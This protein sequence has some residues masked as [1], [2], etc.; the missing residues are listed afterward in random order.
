MNENHA[1][2]CSSPEWASFLRSHVLEPLA[3]MVELGA[4]MVEF[5]PGPG[6]STAWLRE[7]V[8]RLTVVEIDPVAAARLADEH[9]D[10]NV[11]VMVG[12]CSRTELPS[13]SFDSVASFTMLHHL[14]TQAM[15]LAV[16]NEA[17]RLLKPGGVL[18]GS[19]SMASTEL[20]DFHEGDTYNPIDPAR[21]LV[22]LQ[23]SGYQRITLQVGEGMLFTARKGEPAC[24]G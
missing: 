21:L 17:F 7:R 16:L 11:T 15:Q 8:A 22:Y 24:G 3:G 12:D 20:H 2:L 5:G 6:A 10:T 14:P 13:A 18:I 1:A 9:T 19:D 4:D 23:A